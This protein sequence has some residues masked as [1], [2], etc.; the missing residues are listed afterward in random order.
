MLERDQAIVAAARKDERKFFFMICNSCF[1]CASVFKLHLSKYRDIFSCP[2]CKGNKIE[3][4]PLAANKMY[5]LKL[6][7][8]S[9]M[10]LDFL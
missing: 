3:T 4:L 9:R 1:W 7:E 2:V 6:R 5:N 8:S 10:V